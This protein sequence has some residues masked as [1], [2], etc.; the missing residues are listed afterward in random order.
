MCIY[1]LKL[2][3]KKEDSGEIEYSLPTTGMV[4]S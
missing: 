1:I 2:E 4:I 3:Y